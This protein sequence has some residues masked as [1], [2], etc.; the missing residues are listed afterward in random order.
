MN[1]PITGIFVPVVEPPASC[2]ECL[3]KQFDNN[4]DMYCPRSMKG[5]SGTGRPE[6][7]RIKPAV[8][9]EVSQDIP[10]L[11]EDLCACDPSGFLEKEVK[12][13][14][15]HEAANY[16]SVKRQKEYLDGIGKVTRYTGRITVV[17]DE[18]QEGGG[19]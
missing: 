16:V 19:E 9:L 2:F 7:C 18:Q 10:K 5:V 3:I 8:T 1:V 14:L 4:G 12:H 15:A 6:W 11:Q 17:Y 13:E